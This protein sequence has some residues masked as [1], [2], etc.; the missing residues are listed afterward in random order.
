MVLRMRAHPLPEAREYADLMLNELRKV[1]PS[2]LS[3]VD[4][5]DRGGV[6]SSYFEA[7]REATAELAHKLL[8]D[9]QPEPRP[10][11]T[12]VD[13]DPDAE[14]KTVAAALYPYTNLPDDQLLARVRNMSHDEK[15]SV[16]RA[17]VGDRQNRRHKPGRGF[18]RSYYRFDVLSDY[19]AFRDLQRHRLLT[20]EWQD[21]TPQHGYDVPQLVSEAN[22][23]EPYEEVL[24]RSS[25]LYADLSEQ[26]PTE[27]AYAVALAFKVRYTMQFNT[28]E[29]IHLLELR[30]QQQGHPGYRSVCQEMHNLIGQQAGHHA[31]A[32]VM[33]YVDHQ[34]YGLER[35]EAERRAEA[36]RGPSVIGT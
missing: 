24:E 10:L 15:V 34:T 25:E 29:A 7:T 12:L 3:R 22:L 21:L 6:W 14:D 2:F 17:Y 11:V 26:F 28:R 9:T 4:R 1:I 31:L 18:E 32:E 35:L 33:Q 16:L 8:S 5:A 23:A 13:F 20:I 19:G 27:A 30:T 36:R